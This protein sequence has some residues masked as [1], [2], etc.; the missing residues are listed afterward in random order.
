MD[1][2][3]KFLSTLFIYI[4]EK[5]DVIHSFFSQSKVWILMQWM[6]FISKENQ[7]IVIQ[8]IHPNLVP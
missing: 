4:V 6:L 1:V 7:D 8:T 5:F 2:R 3:S